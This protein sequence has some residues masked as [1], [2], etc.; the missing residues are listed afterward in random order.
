[1]IAKRSR[2][3]VRADDGLRALGNGAVETFL[4]GVRQ[5]YDD[6]GAV[7]FG[8]DLFAEI[9]QA[10]VLTLGLGRCVANVV[11]AVV[12]KGD[13][14]HAFTAVAL[15]VADVASQGVAVFDADKDRLFSHAFI[16]KQ[17]LGREGDLCRGVSSHRL[18]DLGNKVV[19]LQGGIGQSLNRAFAL[20]QVGRHDHGVESAFVHAVQVHQDIVTALTKIGSAIKPHRRVAVGV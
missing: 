15:H 4:G 13:V 1:M 17:V 19:G 5:V 12:T 20:R 14:N 6:A 7:H 18:L 10:A 3:R 11:V 9:A 2:R 16:G 8:D